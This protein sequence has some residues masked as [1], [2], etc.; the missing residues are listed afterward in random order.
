MSKMKK[1]SNFFIRQSCEFSSFKGLPSHSNF[2]M[3]S[4]TESSGF[5][6]LDETPVELAGLDIL[7]LN[8]NQLTDSEAAKLIKALAFTSTHSLVEFRLYNNK[9]TRVPYFLR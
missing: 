7:Y 2:K 4:I 3:L 1:L 9:L 8:D 5:Y 6:S